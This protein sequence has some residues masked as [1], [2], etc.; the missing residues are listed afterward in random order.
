MPRMPTRRMW[1]KESAPPKPSCMGCHGPNGVSTNKGVPH[2]AGQRPAYLYH[3]LKEYQSGARGDAAMS[4][5]VKVLNDEALVKVAA[6]YASLEPPPPVVPAAGKAAPA[7][8]DAIQ[9]G[10]AAAAACAGCHGDSGISK[11]AG[12]PSLVGL[13][14]KYLVAAMNAYKSGQ[15]KSDAMKA[16]LSASSDADIANMALFYAL[17]KPARAQTPAVGDQAAGK[18]AATACSACHGN[19]GV[20]ADPATPNLAGQ[21]AQYI[22]AAL[23]AYKDGS[24]SDATMKALASSLDDAAGKNLAAFYANQQPQQPKSDPAAHHER[25]GATVRSLSRRRRQQQRSPDSGVGRAARGL[26]GKGAARLS[27]G[28]AQESADGRHVGWSD[29]GGRRRPR[30]LLFT[31]E[32]AIRRL[33]RPAGQ[34]SES[35]ESHTRGQG[36]PP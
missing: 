17:Q 25:V 8:P 21:D 18:A 5:A 36:N 22:A 31:P 9:A 28:R 13:D 30:R 4:G 1:R 20:G 10:K 32:S 29:D 19:S 24:R 2:L 11:A 7:K 33:C 14:P 6:Y 26:S 23:R 15:R 16:V 3:E 12:V 34:V 27:S 35:S